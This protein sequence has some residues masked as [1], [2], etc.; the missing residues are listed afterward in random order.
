MAGG[1]VDNDY[2]GSLRVLLINVSEGPVCLTRGDRVA[3]AI[4]YGC[5]ISPLLPVQEVEG[6]QREVWADW[7]LPGTPY[8]NNPSSSWRATSAWVGEARISDQV[9][10]AL[11]QKALANYRRTRPPCWTVSRIWPAMTSSSR[12]RTLHP[13]PTDKGSNLPAGVQRGEESQQGRRRGFFW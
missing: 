6:A 4:C 12:K 11:F 3:Q 9:S 10:L 5:A 1:V 2:T 7:A 8:I 13:G